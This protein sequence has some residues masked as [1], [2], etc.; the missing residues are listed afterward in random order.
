[1]ESGKR[2][3]NRKKKNS[4]SDSHDHPKKLV[5]APQKSSSVDNSNSKRR[6]TNAVVP[7]GG[8]K[9]LSFLEKAKA[10]LSGGHFRMINE[11]LYTCSGEEALNYF[12]E[13]PS[14]FNMY[15]TGY[16]EQMSHWPETPVNVIIQWLK[17]HDPYLIVAD[18]GCGDARLAKNVKNKVFSIDLVS[19]DPSVI[20]CDMSNTPLAS[21]SVDVAVFCLSL[22][23]TNFP[24][25]LT[26]A[27]RVLN[28]SGWLLIAEVR[29]RFDPN[30]GGTAPDGFLKAVCDLGFTL[31]SKD[32]SNK[33]FLLFFFKKKQEKRKSKNKE[34]EWPTLKPCLY[35]RR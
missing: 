27:H 35:K 17:E 3:R 4:N 5:S 25:Y 26:E 19:N 31:T 30:N 15:H 12:K 14:L 13:D 1:M 9:Q 22:M 21:S 29:S 2:K 7:D 8:G 34:I 10:R 20:A 18:F 24:S 16:Q 6:K 23:G 11:K 32:Y 28:S 33:M